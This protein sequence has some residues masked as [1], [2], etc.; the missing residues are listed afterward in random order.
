MSKIIIDS[1]VDKELAVTLAN[2]CVQVQK[3][4]DISPI[5]LSTMLNN[6]N[7]LDHCQFLYDQCHCEMVNSLNGYKENFL[8][9]LDNNN[10]VNISDGEYEKCGYLKKTHKNGYIEYCNLHKY[11]HPH[12]EMPPTNKKWDS[13]VTHEFITKDNNQIIKERYNYSIYVIYQNYL[14]K[15][16]SLL[17]S[18][19]YYQIQTECTTQSIKI[20]EM[21]LSELLNNMKTNSNIFKSKVLYEHIDLSNKNNT[22]IEGQRPSSYYYLKVYTYKNATT[23]L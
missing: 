3:E 21:S 14:N 18:L 13:V 5:L 8:G 15:L 6:V 23:A 16:Y 11:L 22:K 12:P 10:K 20:E 4:F 1:V 2:L 17:K 7:F 9:A 19:F